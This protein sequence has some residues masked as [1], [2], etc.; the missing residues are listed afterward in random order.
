MST[1]ED[2]VQTLAIHD[3]DIHEAHCNQRGPEVQVLMLRCLLRI[4]AITRGR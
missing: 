4:A 1:Q 2:Q 3:D